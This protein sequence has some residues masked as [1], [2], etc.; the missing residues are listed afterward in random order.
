MSVRIIWILLY[1]KSST[2]LSWCIFINCNCIDIYLGQGRYRTTTMQQK[3]CAEP[4]FSQL[5][6]SGEYGGPWQCIVTV[7]ILNISERFIHWFTQLVAKTNYHWLFPFFNTG[8]L[9]FLERNSLLVNF[10]GIT[11]HNFS[12]IDNA[13]NLKLI[14][15]D[16]RQS[17][18]YAWQLRA[19]CFGYFS[20][21]RT[22]PGCF[23]YTFV[24]LLQNRNKIS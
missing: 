7:S 9:M 10:A 5:F 3:F 11:K 12:N 24:K 18:L 17:Q 2:E 14:S 6:T 1:D 20:L 8:L 21:H 22:S 16:H 15:T 4:T 23:W 19:H 13:I